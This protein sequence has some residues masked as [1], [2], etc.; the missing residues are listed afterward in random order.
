M[1]TGTWC[2][3]GLCWE[4]RE[5]VCVDKDGRAKQALYSWN[6]YCS[7]REA[8]RPPVTGSLQLCSNSLQTLLLMPCIH[9]KINDLIS[10]LL[11]LYLTTFYCKYSLT[12]RP[13]LLRSFCVEPRLFLVFMHPV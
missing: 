4:F 5:Q 2:F 10:S 12:F 8:V 11:N 13:L 7:D 3:H 6:Y 1:D 9:L